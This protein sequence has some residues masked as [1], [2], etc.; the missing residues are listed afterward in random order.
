MRTISTKTQQLVNLSQYVSVAVFGALFTRK[1]F[2][3]GKYHV[4]GR[5][6]VVGGVMVAL[7]SCSWAC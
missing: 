7:I 2:D 5:A 3:E 4:I 6:P 1:I